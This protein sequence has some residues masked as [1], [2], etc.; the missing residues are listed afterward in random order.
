MCTNAT[1]C[2]ANVI[3]KLC[4]LQAALFVSTTT[5]LFQLLWQK[6]NRFSNSVVLQLIIYQLALSET[7]TCTCIHIQYAVYGVVS[8]P[9][10]NFSLGLAQLPFRFGHGLVMKPYHLG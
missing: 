7:M 5:V 8:C 4:S 10:P 2:V 9:F 1:V 6:S 3:E